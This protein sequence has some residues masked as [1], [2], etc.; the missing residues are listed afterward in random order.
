MHQHGSLSI[1]PSARILPYFPTLVNVARL[2]PLCASSQGFAV[3][4]LGRTILLQSDR[5]DG[6][7]ATGILG[8][9]TYEGVHASLFLTVQ[10]A[11]RC[12]PGKDVGCA[13]VDHHVNPAMNVLLA[14]YDGVI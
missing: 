11:L 3:L 6:N 7:E 9:E 8:A 10:V 4:D 5:L 14:E 12:G 13:L 1:F 2:L